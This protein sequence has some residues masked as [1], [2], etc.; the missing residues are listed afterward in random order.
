MGASCAEA[1]ARKRHP[2][3]HVLNGESSKEQ[4]MRGLDKYMAGPAAPAAFI[5]LP[6]PAVTV[7]A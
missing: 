6:Q 5:A 7:R 1:P 2:D 4:S 3:G